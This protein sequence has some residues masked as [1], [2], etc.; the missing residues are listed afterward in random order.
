M[1]K[2]KTRYCTKAIASGI[3]TWFFSAYVLYGLIYV[4]GHQVNDIFFSLLVS[5]VLAVVSFLFG[6]YTVIRLFSTPWSTCKILAC[7]LCLGIVPA[8]WIALTI[9]R[10]DFAY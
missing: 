6:L 7:F 10:Y 5:L 4:D 8:V 2:A 3:L 9:S 1:P